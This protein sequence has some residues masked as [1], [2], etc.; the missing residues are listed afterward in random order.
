MGRLLRLGAKLVVNLIWLG[1]LGLIAKV[2]LPLLSGKTFEK[3]STWV[4]NQ[5]ET[6][7]NK[8]EGIRK[9]LK[10]WK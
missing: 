2:A 6:N 10:E 5:L 3:A 4:L 8:S 1:I 9:E 7:W